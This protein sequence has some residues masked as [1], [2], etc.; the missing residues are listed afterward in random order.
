M[1]NSNVELINLLLEFNANLQIADATGNYPIHYISRA[2]FHQ[3][4][5]SIHDRLSIESSNLQF[6]INQTNKKGKTGLHLI[7]KR[8]NGFLKKAKKLAQLMLEMDAEPNIQDGKGNTPLHIAAG[9]GALSICELLIM[10]GADRSLRNMQ[11][12]V[13]SEL[14]LSKFSGSLILDDLEIN[15][16][17]KNLGELLKV[18]KRSRSSM[19]T[20]PSCMR[21]TSPGIKRTNNSDLQLFE[22]ALQNY[23]DDLKNEIALKVVINV[24]NYFMPVP[25]ESMF[26]SINILWTV[27]EA[28]AHICGVLSIQSSPERF[29]LFR[30]NADGQLKRMSE[31]ATV[32]SFNLRAKDVVLFQEKSAELEG[33]F[34]PRLNKV[35]TPKLRRTGQLPSVFDDNMVEYTGHV[36]FVEK[37]YKKYNCT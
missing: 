14:I 35:K 31:Y 18:T 2:A 28:V 16:L 26:T 22:E 5:V 27:R 9:V 12:K 34:T 24:S 11:N 7:T 25:R 21:S 36:P 37:N 4:L 3:A 10:H 19:S 15:F 1:K 13:P 29:G 6:S 20:V 32:A 17:R 23:K 33:I 30:P 8:H